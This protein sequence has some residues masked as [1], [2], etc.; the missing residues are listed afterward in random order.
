M[1]HQTRMEVDLRD[2]VNEDLPAFAALLQSEA[3]SGHFFGLQSKAEV[4]N[5]MK[6]LQLSMQ[7]AALRQNAAVTVHTITIN[8]EP[9]GYYVLRGTMDPGVI[10]LNVLVIEPAWRR[11]GLARYAVQTVRAT[12]EEMG[13]HM[14]VRCLPAS[15]SMMD[16]LKSLRFEEQRIKQRSVRNFKS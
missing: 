6:N 3:A 5:Y 4:T 1:N 14:I 9:K 7:A 2:A 8:S 15:V 12:L 13:Y 11:R 16:L 10:D